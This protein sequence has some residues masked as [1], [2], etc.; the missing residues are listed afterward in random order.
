MITRRSVLVAGI[1]IAG[2]AAGVAAGFVEPVRRQ[3]NPERGAPAQLRITF[4]REQS[5]VAALAAAAREL[6]ASQGVLD[7]VRADHAAHAAAIQSALAAYPASTTPS[8][9]AGTTST[10]PPSSLARLRDAERTAARLAAA[11]S[12]ALSGANAA[13]LASISACESVHAE[14]FV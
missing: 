12:K 6:P 1:V 4:E 7:Q 8:T 10:S 14:L 2:G 13:L 11:E 3:V 9:P 5:L